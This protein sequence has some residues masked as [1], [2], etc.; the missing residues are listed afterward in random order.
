MTRRLLLGL[1][2]ALAILPALL[3][4]CAPQEPPLRIG[5]HAW[6][7]YESLCLAQ[8]LGELPPGVALQHG[9]RAADT[10][11]A[12]RA[13]SVDA[14]TLTLDEMLQLRAA[15]TPLTAVL[16]FDSSSG[17]DV[18]L[19]RPGIGRLQDLAGRRIGYEPSAVGALVLAAALAQAGLTERAITPVEL[20]LTEQVAAWKAGRVDAMVTYEPTAAQLQAQGA[21]RLFD[22]RQMPD[23]IFDVLA[24]RGDRIGN[25]TAALRKTVETHFRMRAYLN[26]NRDD[27]VYRMAEH[28]GVTAEDVRRALAGVTLPELAGNRYALQPGSRFEVAAQRLHR[29]MVERGMLV[30]PDALTGLFTAD[31]L[32]TAAMNPR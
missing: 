13:G 24:V 17:A 12:L 21:V 27:A 8:E 6:V 16:I 32:P 30:K 15:G 10:M 23:T 29:L 14:G 28:Q 22:S 20:P 31:Y 4:A 7:G 26:R 3:A 2:L 1:R 5:T 18:L 11:A 19:A 25:R 9:Q